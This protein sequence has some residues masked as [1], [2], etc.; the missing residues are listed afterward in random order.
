MRALLCI[1]VFVACAPCLRAQSFSSSNLQLLAGSGFDDR[2]TGASTRSGDLLTLSAERLDVRAWGDSF[3]FVDINFGALRDFGGA[4]RGHSYQS[5]AE[6]QPRLSL[7][8]LGVWRRSDTAVIRDLFLAAQVNLSDSGFRAL[9]LG[10]GA[11]LR[12]AG[13]DS[14]GVN[15]YARDDNFNSPTAQLT[16]FWLAPVGAAWLTEGF[17][18]VAGSD[19]DGTDV[20]F[21]PRLLRRFGDHWQVGIEWYYHH[22]RSVA[23]SAPQLMLKWLP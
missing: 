18:D 6:W 17:L 9:L 20:V 10:V 14:L 15:L 3:A 12:I 7:G 21:Q 16:A 22:N 23:A 11:D 13:F 4:R 8:H 1:A 2:L 19:A 5:Y